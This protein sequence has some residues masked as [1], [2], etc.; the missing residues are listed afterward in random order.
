[1]KSTIFYS[2]G[3]SRAPSALLPTSVLFSHIDQESDIVTI[4]VIGF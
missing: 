2:P 4:D 3:L 1:M